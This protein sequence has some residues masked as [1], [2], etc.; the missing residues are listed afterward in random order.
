[1]T[2]VKLAA[3]GND[4][5]LLDNRGG[6]LTGDPAPLVRRLCPR[7]TSVGADGL[8]L[9]ESSVRADF[10]YRHFNSDGSSAEMCGNG[11]RAACHYMAAKGQVPD[12]MTFEIAGTIHRARRLETGIELE[13]PAPIQI[14]PLPGLAEDAPDLH[15]GG[16]LITGVP[17]FVLF[18][19]SVADVDV[20]SIGKEYRGHPFFPRGTN[21]DFVEIVSPDAI[22]VRTYERGVEGETLACGTGAAASAVMAHLQKH[23]R[24]P[25]RVST[26]GGLLTVDWGEAYTPLFLRGDARIVYEAKLTTDT[27][28]MEEADD[29]F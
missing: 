21:V 18:G 22:K 26:P 7:R 5:I 1:M 11:A 12:K 3:A 16:F 9:I 28:A 25:V 19:E 24:P 17:H 13:M 29:R 14:T 27:I 2:F 6:L 15:E 23:V 20:P 4:F 8:I 10:L